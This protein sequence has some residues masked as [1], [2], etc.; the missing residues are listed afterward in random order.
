MLDSTHASCYNPRMANEFQVRDPQAA[1]AHAARFHG[2]AL[3]RIR[4]ECGWS[5]RA[6]ARATGISTSHLCKLERGTTTPNTST[7]M[8][9]ARAFEVEP[10]WVYE[11]LFTQDAQTQVQE[12]QTP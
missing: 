2:P 6:F 5:I 8:R 4:K 12:E 11:N 10:G 9:I 3:A 1:Q 7:L